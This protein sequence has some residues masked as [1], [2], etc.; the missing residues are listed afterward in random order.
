MSEIL[1]QEEIDA[2]LQALNTGE[3]SVKEIEQETKEKKV[4]KYD[5]KSPKKL[6]NDQLRTLNMIHENFARALNTFLSGYLRTKTQIEVLSVEE[7]SY[8][9][10]SNSISN[11]ALLAIIDFN[12]LPGQIIFEISSQLSFSIIDRILGGI[13]S[14]TG[15]I[16]AFTEI[17]ITL[18]NKIIR[19]IVKYFIDPWENV[20]ELTP[21]V[22]KIETNSQ[23]AQIASYNETV[24]LITFRATIGETEGLINICIPH[25]VL[26]PVLPKLSTKYWFSTISKKSTDEEKNIIEKRVKKA[27]LN[28]KCIVGEANITLEDF[29]NLQ[30]GDVI[31]L[32]KTIHDEIEIAVEDRVKYLGKPG[33]IKNKLSVKITKV[34]E[35]DDDEYDE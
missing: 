18:L 31:T 35:K 1:S 14:Y 3:V 2:L 34:I 26:E 33:T 5:F 7:I 9:E 30:E 21:T 6:A 23:F 20:I 13:G 11:P 25:I 32:D 4:K 15:E 27:T 8:Y 28:I 10:F 22:D 16:R 17:E 29:I 12:P 19:Q 24:A